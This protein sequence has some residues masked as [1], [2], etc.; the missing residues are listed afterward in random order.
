MNKAIGKIV[1]FILFSSTIMATPA[2][3]DCTYGSYG[4]TC[5]YPTD[6]IINKEVKN[7]ITNVYVEHL[8]STDPTFSPGS[9]I[10]FKLIVRNTSGETF[11]PVEVVDQFPDYLTYVSSSVAGNY[12]AGTRRLVMTLE[13][14]I[15]GETREIEVTAKVADKT[16]FNDD[17]S[18]FCSS[19]YTKVTTPAR[20]NG[21]DDTSEFCMTTRINGSSTLPVA[22][23][24]DLVTMIPFLSLGGIG[25]ALLKKKN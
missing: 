17:T 10:T 6:L 11:H 13:H 14:L 5:N 7:P 25:L 1:A 9:T 20:P 16:A 23:F 4:S 3:A 18:F 19:N 2:L 15:A 24:N 22:G 12:D 21:D 8:G